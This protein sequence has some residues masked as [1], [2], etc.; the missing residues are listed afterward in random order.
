[1]EIKST[2]PTV[3]IHSGARQLLPAQVAAYSLKR[4]SSRPDAF[5]VRILARESYRYFDAYE[6]RPF[7]RAGVRRKW[8]NDGPRAF[9]PLRFAAPELMAYSGRAVVLEPDVFA[10]GVILREL[11]VGKRLWGDADDLTILRSLIARAIPAMPVR[12]SC[13]A[14]A[15]SFALPPPVSTPRSPSSTSAASR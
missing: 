7:L 12:G 14:S 10:V 11:L 4:N 3:F 2:T 9:A 1:M 8:R 15:S 13:S 6:G 5:Q